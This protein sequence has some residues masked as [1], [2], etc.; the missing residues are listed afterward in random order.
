[1][2]GLNICLARS[3]LAKMCS[4]PPK[5]QGHDSQKTLMVDAGSYLTRARIEPEI[6]HA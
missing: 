2:E 4:K 6:V 1:M 5:I 3:I